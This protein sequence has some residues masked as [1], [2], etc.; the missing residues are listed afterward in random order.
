MGPPLF[1]AGLMVT[2]PGR[3]A[4]SVPSPYTVQAPRL[5]RLNWKLPV[6]RCWNACGWAGTSVFIDLM[7]HSSSACLASSG[8][9]SLIQTP[10]LPDCWNFHGLAKSLPPPNRDPLNGLPSSVVSLGL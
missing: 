4:L 7:T 3:S 9:S 5:G 10:D 8:Y 1:G 6:C 2:N